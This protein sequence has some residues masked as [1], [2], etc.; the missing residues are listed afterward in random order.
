MMNKMIKLKPSERTIVLQ[1][2]DMLEHDETS[3]LEL[4]KV[5]ESHDNSSGAYV[6]IIEDLEFAFKDGQIA[7]KCAEIRKSLG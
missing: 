6:E 5:A 7:Q 1:L 4:L 3:P 2:L